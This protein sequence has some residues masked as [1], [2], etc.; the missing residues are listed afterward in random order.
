MTLPESEV[1]MAAEE[2]CRELRAAS[3]ASNLELPK[4]LRDRFIAVRSTLFRLGIFDPILARFDSATVTQ[5]SPQEIAEELALLV[6]K[7]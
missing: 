1:K 4:A 3:A 2:V 7:L 6:E 5:A